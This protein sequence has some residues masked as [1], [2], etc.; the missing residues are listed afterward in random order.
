MNNPTYIDE[1]WAGT[2]KWMVDGKDQFD[3]LS[4]GGWNKAELDGFVNYLKS[5]GWQPPS[6]DEPA[7][8][9]PS[10]AG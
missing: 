7:V 4:A 3:A 8:A 10:M 5:I 2:M 9:A 6:K 1:L